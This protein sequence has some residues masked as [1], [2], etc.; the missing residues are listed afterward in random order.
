MDEID[1]EALARADINLLVALEALMQERSVTRAAKRL[2]LSQPAMSHTLRRLRDLFDDEL[3]VR[4]G[5]KMVPTPLAVGLIGPVRAA[6]R[7]LGSVFESVQPFRPGE[8]HAT[9]RISAFDFAQFT[10][11]PRLA[12]ILG[13]RAPNVRLVARPYEPDPARALADGRVDLVIGLHREPQEPCHRVL[14]SERLSCVVRQGHPCLAAPLTPEQYAALPH[15]VVSPLGR[16]AG[17][18][19]AAL[20]QL[21]LVRNVAFTTPQLFS[22]AVAVCQSDMILTGIERQL[23]SVMRFLSLA[24]LE[25]PVALPPFEVAMTWHE[26][27]TSDVLHQFLRE[28]VVDVSASVKAERP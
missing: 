27:R 18:V 23:R 11:L 25:P 22:A 14:S 16:P 15:V 28:L 5:Q 10:L 21:G 26:R 12:A 17:Y 13:A 2:A 24:M 7:E 1:V 9:F 19:D 3:F 4:S 20:L 6:L 8:V